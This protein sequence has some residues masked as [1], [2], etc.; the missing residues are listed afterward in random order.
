MDSLFFGWDIINDKNK[1]IRIKTRSKEMEKTFWL[2]KVFE[3]LNS[4]TW[5]IEVYNLQVH[6]CWIFSLQVAKKLTIISVPNLQRV[7]LKNFIM[8]VLFQS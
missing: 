8:Y 7:D 2:T 5:K 4:N 6:L 1:I 3:P